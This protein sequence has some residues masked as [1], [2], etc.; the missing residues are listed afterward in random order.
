MRILF[1]TQWFQPESFF[2]GL[3]FAKALKDKGHDVEVLTGFPNY[4]GGKMFPGYYIRPYQRE[5]ME[6]IKIHRVPLY[7]S[8]DKSAI[9]RII[10]YLSFSLSAF[11]MGPWLIKK[12]DVIYVYNL[13][14]LGLPAFL[15]RF[16]FKSKV[17][18]DVQDLWPESVASSGMLNNK[19]LLT[20]L[21][22]ICNFVYRK[23]DQLIVL[24]PGFKSHLIKRGVPSEK[25]EVIYNWCDEKSIQ[26]KSS[27]ADK[28]KQID[29]SD[30]FVILYAG[31]MGI[32]QELET[33]L[34]S[35]EQ[36]GT[37]MSDVLFVFIGDGADRKRLERKANDMKLDNVV[38]LPSRPIHEMNEVYAMADVL[39]VHLMDQPLFRIT[40]PSKTQAYLYMG[41]PIIM[42]LRG[43]SA[44]LVEK[45]GAG[46]VCEP[47]NSDAITEGVRT[48]RNADAATRNR[49]GMNGHQYYMQHLSFEKGVH[50]VEQLMLSLVKT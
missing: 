25:I 2:K 43:D 16:L 28:T 29:T 8:H 1:L 33:V 5:T 37:M 50:N 46:I 40:I 14:T 6:G 19:F 32:V 13:V 24:S 45:A 12:P 30:K 26:T 15:F 11:F 4:P 17:I 35:A 48:L 49:M 22:R 42:A 27:S 7:P 3:P 39:I 41:K 23:A 18:I 31:S 9:R 47:G 21:N 20:V 38:F 10:N 36:C 34:I 44:M